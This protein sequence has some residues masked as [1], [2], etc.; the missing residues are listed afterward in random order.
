MTSA[1]VRCAAFGA[2]AVLSVSVAPLSVASAADISGAGATFPY[3]IYAKW[4]DA[5]KKETGTGLNYQSIGSGGGIKQIKAKT[6]TFGASDMPLKPEELEQAGLIQFP[7]IMGGVVPVV[8]LKG[9][10]AGEVQL[11]GTVLANIYMGEITKWNDP[12]IK[13]LNPNVNLPN[14]AIAPVYRSDGSG[15]NFL[16]TDYLSKTS[17]KF[18]TQIG[19]N[20]SVQWPAGIGAKGNEGVA[21][22]VKQTD[23]SI[24]YVEYAYAKQNNIT[25]LDLQNKDGKTVAP[26][27]EA[28]QAAAANADWANSKGYYVLLT[29]EPGAE[30]WPI[31]GASFILMYKTP[32]DAASSAEALKFFDWA[33]K[34]GAKMATELDYVP[35]PDAVVSLVQKTWA[36]TI[37]ADGKPVWTA[38]A[39]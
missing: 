34:N 31:T 32:Q 21:N 26:K 3:P 23:G 4:A 16:F 24:G 19:A 2:L 5:Y 8:N 30:S 38:S 37:Q 29:D 15:T 9:I 11:S 12:Q 14:T 18:K 35:M 6:V 10:K 33:Y 39:K 1:F 7:M 22:M 13:A 28:F 25:H 27:I 20:T 36:Q 17:P